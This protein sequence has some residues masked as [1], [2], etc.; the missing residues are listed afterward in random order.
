MSRGQEHSS[1]SSKFSPHL[2]DNFI[3]S[4]GSEKSSYP[5]LCPLPLPNT[6]QTIPSLNCHSNSPKE[7]DT[8]ASVEC[9][10]DGS[11]HQKNPEVGQSFFLCSLGSLWGQSGGKGWKQQAHTIH[12]TLGL[13][14]VG[15]SVVSDKY[16]L[17]AYHVLNTFFSL[18]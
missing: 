7:A 11:R 10:K 5:T 13:Q 9:P 2:R 6:S 4:S 8:W 1:L 3:H 18:L 15:L 12:N 14:K 16:S 17:S